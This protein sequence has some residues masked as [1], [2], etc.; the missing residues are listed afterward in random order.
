[1]KTLVR[2]PGFIE[3]ATKMKTIDKQSIESSLNE[4]P[5]TRSLNLNSRVRYLPDYLLTYMCVF[6]G[7]TIDC[8]IVCT[9]HVIII[10]R[11]QW[12]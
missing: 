11:V 7:Q 2:N 3:A 1:M 9:C 6:V 10:L 8:E 5:D 4:Y 12:Q